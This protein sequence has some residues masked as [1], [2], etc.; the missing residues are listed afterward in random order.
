ML[1]EIKL[2]ADGFEIETQINVRILQ[3]GLRIHEVPS[4]EAGRIHGDSNLNTFRDG[5]RVLKT[6]VR[7]W[8]S[9]RVERLRTEEVA[10]LQLSTPQPLSIIASNP[11]Q[12]D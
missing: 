3:A 8:V 5:W 9:P 7:E 4:F 6:I 11:H 2:D 12:F 1:A 10:S